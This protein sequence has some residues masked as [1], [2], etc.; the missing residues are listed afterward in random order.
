MM[1]FIFGYGPR[2]K[3]L[4]LEEHRTC[5]RC[6]NHQQWRR[7]E[8]RNWIT[9]FFIP[10]IPTGGKVLVQCPICSHGWQEE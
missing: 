9:L 1:F 4:G 5:A 7:S 2:V 3:D 6:G 8:V 10:V